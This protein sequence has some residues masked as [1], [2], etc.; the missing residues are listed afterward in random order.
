MVEN[1]TLSIIR[2]YISSTFLSEKS[3]SIHVGK[4]T[5]NPL[6]EP[7]ALSITYYVHLTVII[8]LRD[9]LELDNYDDLPELDYEMQMA[10]RKCA[11]I[12]HN[13]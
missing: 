4:S 8:S 11:R 3:T 10:D 13:M 2:N 6:L 9:Q 1:I 5:S 12:L 7:I